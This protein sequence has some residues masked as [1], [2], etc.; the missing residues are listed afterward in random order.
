M[1]LKFPD[2]LKKHY[3]KIFFPIWILFSAYQVYW[4]FLYPNFTFNLALD[5]GIVLLIL[6]L[7]AMYSTVLTVL[8]Y[9]VVQKVKKKRSF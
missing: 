5:G 3:W 2:G 8:G 7:T 9:L 6:A 1:L 4:G